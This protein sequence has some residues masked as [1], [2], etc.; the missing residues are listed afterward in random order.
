MKNINKFLAT[1]YSEEKANAYVASEEASLEEA[2]ATN[3]R[4]EIEFAEHELAVAQ[5]YK[6]CRSTLSANIELWAMGGRDVVDVHNAVM[7]LWDATTDELST[8]ELNA[9]DESFATEIVNSAMGN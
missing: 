6:L 5:L 4:E 7:S 3:D 8:D 9:K 2:K 1:E